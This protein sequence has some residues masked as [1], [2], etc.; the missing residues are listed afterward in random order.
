MYSDPD[1]KNCDGDCQN[2]PIFQC[3]NDKKDNDDND[4]NDSDN[5]NN[6]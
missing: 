6:D 4:N 1:P 5:S 2:C 3:F